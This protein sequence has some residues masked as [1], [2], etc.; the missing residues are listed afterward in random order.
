M[1]NNL[2]KI[3]NQKFTER[4]LKKHIIKC[5]PTTIYNGIYMRLY[6]EKKIKVN[7]ETIIKKYWVYIVVP[8]DYTLHK[9]DS[10]I[11]NIW[12]ECCNHLSEFIVS[13]DNKINIYI[14]SNH[15]QEDKDINQQINLLDVIKNKELVY[16][17][18]FD[19]TTKINIEILDIITN[20]KNNENILL[21]NRNN[22]VDINCSNCNNSSNKICSIC[23]KINCC[24]NSCM[25][26][27]KTLLPLLN[28]PRMGTCCYGSK[29]KVN[30]YYS[31]VESKNDIQNNISII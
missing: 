27:N 12:V 30:H 20:K 4:G 28:S 14:Y 16:H 1:K 18:D 17:Y 11:R 29:K 26:D 25:C 15:E 2:C 9:L 3:C 19:N 22:E 10:V 31:L 6:G 8:L 21:I 13:K 5:I 23:N 7:D 24:Y